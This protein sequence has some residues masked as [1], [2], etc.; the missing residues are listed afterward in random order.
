MKDFENF[1]NNLS[2]KDWS[3]WPF[4]SLRPA[5]NQ[6]MDN[7]FLVKLTAVFGTIIGLMTFVIVSFIEITVATLNGSVVIMTFCWFLFFF[8]YKYTFARYW[9][10]RAS[11]LQDK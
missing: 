10:I 3:W 5:K 2:D 4:L 11:R 9:N 1:M 7:A 8:L 6:L